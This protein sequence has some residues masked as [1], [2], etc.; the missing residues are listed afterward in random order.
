A[1][2]AEIDEDKLRLKPAEVEETW[3]P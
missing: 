3:R 1:L 2:R